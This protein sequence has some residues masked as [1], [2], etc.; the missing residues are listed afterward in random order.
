MSAISP[1]QREN[2]AHIEVFGRF[3]ESWGEVR[4][5]LPKSQAVTAGSP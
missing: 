1:V 4:V 3:R 2:L 5:K